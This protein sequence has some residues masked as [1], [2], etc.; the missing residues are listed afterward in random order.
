[1]TNVEQLREKLSADVKENEIM[2]PYTTF[3]IGGPAE[4]FFT[5]T[6]AEEVIKAVHVAHELGLST[7]VFGGG[8]N[9]VV[10][11]EGIKGLVIRMQLQGL[12]IDGVDVTV[13]AGI[14]SGLVSMKVTNAGVTG[15]EW[16]V[17]LPGTIGGAVRGNA[18]M[19]GGEIKDSLIEVLV[20]KDGE[21]ITMKNE[22]CGF[23]YRESIFKKQ[24]GMI[25][26]AAQFTLEKAEDAEEAK[27]KLKAHLLKKKEQQ[28]VEHPTAGCVFVN[29]KPANDEEL[30][31]LRKSLDLDKDEVIPVTPA[32]TVPAAW[33]IDCAQLKGFTVGHVSVSDKHAN[34]FINDGEGTAD[35]VVALIAEVKTKVR[36][37]TGAVV[38]LQEEVEYVGF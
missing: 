7:F 19:Y 33:I 14:A 16:A 31:S 3:K 37:I 22:E 13:S 30:Q 1:M 35:N 15:F 38:M 27:A 10:S 12:E 36:N 34:F 24:P 25:I 11:D 9:M 23:A 6:S 28:P 32:G 20:V 29:W 4:F 17:G 2:A 26:L 21:V 5:A 8:S 18:G